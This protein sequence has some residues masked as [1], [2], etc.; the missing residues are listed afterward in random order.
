MAKLKKKTSASTAPLRTPDGRYIVVRGRLWRAINPH[1]P[2]AKRKRLV[3]ELMKAR[4]AV[5]ASHADMKTQREA[6]AAVHKAK[7]ALGERGSVWWK[8][9]APDFNRKLAKN[10]PYAAWWRKIEAAR[11]M[12]A[13]RRPPKN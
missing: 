2:E 6:R 1:L 9:G 4:R 3:R 13:Q 12:R 5:G 10:T 7:V 8:D 11:T